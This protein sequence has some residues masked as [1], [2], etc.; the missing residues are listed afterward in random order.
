MA[1]RNRFKELVDRMKK[2]RYQFWK[3]T[4]LAQNTAYRLYDDPNYIPGATVM[5]KICQT[6]AGVQPGDFLEYIPDQDKE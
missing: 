1:V 2:T 5:N 6:Y 4:K 3:D